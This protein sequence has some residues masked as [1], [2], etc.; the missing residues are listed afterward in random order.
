MSQ[1]QI[2]SLDQAR[3]WYDT[4]SLFKDSEPS[5]LPEYYRAYLSK[6]PDSKALLWLMQEDDFAFCYP[7]VLTPV[8][9]NSEVFLQKYH[10]YYDISTV[11]GYGGPL[12]NNLSKSFVKKAWNCFDEWAQEEKVVAEFTRFSPYSNNYLLAHPKASVE[13]NRKLAVSYLPDSQEIFWQSLDSK[14]RNMIRKAKKQGLYVEEMPLSCIKQFQE[15]YNSTMDRNDASN[16]F[17]YDNQYYQ[18]L[19]A[20]GHNT[21]KLFGIYHQAKLVSAAIILI[22]NNCALYHLSATDS[23]YNSFGAGNLALWHIS[24]Y[25]IE[26]GVLFF[27]LGGG[28]TTK[29]NDS[30]WRYKRSNAIGETSFYIGKRIINTTIYHEMVDL[31]TT[32]KGQVPSSALLFYRS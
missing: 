3:K 22:H 4:L 1:V 30:L 31:W 18:E 2:I 24:N 7:F 20:L 17:Y 16:F 11:Y 10:Q 15:L 12:V 26:Q 14:T 28:R 27:S 5:F 21:L 9:G 13:L 19:M 29:P 8:S 25:L 6:S 32:A 23:Q